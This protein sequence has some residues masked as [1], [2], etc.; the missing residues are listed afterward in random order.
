MTHLFTTTLQMMEL[1]FLIGFIVAG[2]I[3][4]IALV[5]DHYNLLTQQDKEMLH[6]HRINK[7]RRKVRL[8]IE[9]TIAEKYQYPDDLRED[10]R[11]GINNDTPYQTDYRRSKN[12]TRLVYLK[13]E[14][15]QRQQN[16]QAKK[17]NNKI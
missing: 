5:A 11:R 10:Y 2:V 9:E 13:K 7:L 1:T 4:L 3:R 12:D 16:A 8:L 15:K 14:E 6:L 17:D